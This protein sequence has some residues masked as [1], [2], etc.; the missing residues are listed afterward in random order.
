MYNP[1]S[2]FKA[3]SEEEM[4]F[5]WFATGTPTFL[6]RRLKV[7]HFDVR[8]FANGGIEATDSM[9]MDYRADNPNPIPLLYQTGY[10]T[11]WGYD[12][13]ARIYSLGFPNEEVKYGFLASLFPEYVPIQDWR[14]L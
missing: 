9:I 7:L 14:E 1:F 3:F 2:L 8:Q 10:L 5:Y 6:V 11:I 12:R 13:K 4:A